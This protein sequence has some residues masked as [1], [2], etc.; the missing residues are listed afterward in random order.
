MTAPRPEPL[1]LRECED[2]GKVT[3]ELVM[4]GEHAPHWVLVEGETYLVNCVGGAMSEQRPSIGRIV[5]F[6]GPDGDPG[7]YAGIIVRV[8]GDEKATVVDLVTFGP[9]SMYHNNHVPFSRD[10]APGH[11]TWPPRA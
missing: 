8:H 3:S 10:P 9:H 1:P 4:P 6:T 2:C 7:P 11:W 5:H